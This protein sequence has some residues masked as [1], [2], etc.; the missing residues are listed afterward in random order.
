MEQNLSLKQNQSICINQ[1]LVQAIELLTLNQIDLLNRLNELSLENVFLDFQEDP[2]ADQQMLISLD[3]LA[4][5]RTDNIKDSTFN[6]G[7]ADLQEY[8]PAADHCWRESLLFQL[9]LTD[10]M[11]RELDIANLIIDSL[12]DEGY[13]P[14]SIQEFCQK[15]SILKNEFDKA[16]KTV[17]DL[18]PS[19]IGSLNMIEYL[20]GQTN[21]PLLHQMIQSHLE[22][23]ASNKLPIISKKMNISVD[24]VYRL[25][26]ELKGLN[27]YPCF[28]LQNNK[29]NARYLIPD[30]IIQLVDGEIHI[31]LA[32]YGH[33]ISPSKAYMDLYQ[34][35]VGEA[36]LY[37]TNKL[38]QARFILNSLQIRRKNML[39]VSK[40][41]AENQYNFLFLGKPL[42]R[43]TMKTVA[44]K[45]NLSAST[46][47]RIVQNKYLQCEKGIFPMSFFFVQGPGEENSAHAIKIRIKRLIDQENPLSPLSDQALANSLKEAGLDIQR[48]TVAK[49]RE[50]LG[51]PSSRQRKR[52]R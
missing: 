33:M 27:P 3:Q 38:N 29:D 44:E 15:H 14:Y 1:Q 25:L 18:E 21:N 16:R 11:G 45:N 42:N 30:V 6:S 10:L 36:K 13:F 34:G 28:G 50:E 7:E 37:L 46:V 24:K 52:Y 40:T 39:A 17:M 31:E 43:L 41:I 8:A 2:L 32:R 49:Y 23:L 47:S 35:A 9:K 51:F 48:R 26:E 20:T 19:G 22:D 4:T 12:T 5:M